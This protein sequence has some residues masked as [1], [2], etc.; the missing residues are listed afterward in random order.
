MS[1]CADNGKVYSLYG[2]VVHK[3]TAGHGH[4]I[5]Y[6]KHLGTWYEMNDRKTTMVDTQFVLDQSAYMLFYE[7]ERTGHTV[8]LAQISKKRKIDT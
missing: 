3:G 7:R 4:Y 5:A 2:V 6:I 1:S 8:Q